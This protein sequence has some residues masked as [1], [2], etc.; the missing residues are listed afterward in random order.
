MVPPGKCWKWGRRGAFKTFTSHIWLLLCSSDS[1]SPRNWNWKEGLQGLD[2][3]LKELV[4]QFW[5]LR[6][7]DDWGQTEGNWLTRK[8]PNRGGLALSQECSGELQELR[9]QTTVGNICISFRV[10]SVIL[11]QQ[12]R[13]RKESWVSP[14][15]SVSPPMSGSSRFHGLWG[16][17][18][19]SLCA[20][21]LRKKTFEIE[22]LNW[23]SS[24]GKQ[25]SS[26]CVFLPGE[27]GRLQF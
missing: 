4:L 9:G 3:G 1:L 7:K 25:T 18:P 13:G 10:I 21:N 23:P 20:V 16:P 15:S 11:Q 12:Q 5:L 24:E 19:W 17:Q 8:C 27:G 26:W 2:R 22:N 6:V 14:L